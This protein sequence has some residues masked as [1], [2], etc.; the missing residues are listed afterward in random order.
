MSDSIGFLLGISL[1][2]LTVEEKF[3]DEIEGKRD[4]HDEKETTNFGKGRYW[5]IASEHLE[6][7]HGIN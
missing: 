7:D 1:A 4:S 5:G 2:H 3:V 6:I